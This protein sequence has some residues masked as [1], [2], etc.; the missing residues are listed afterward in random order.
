MATSKKFKLCNSSKAADYYCVK[1]YQPTDDSATKLIEICKRQKQLDL[2]WKVWQERYLQ[3]LREKL[4]LEHKQ[5]RFE[6][7]I[8]PKEGSIV[9]V[10]NKSVTRSNWKL[11]KI[12][13]L[14]PSNDIEVRVVEILRLGQS[15][16]PLAIN[17][18]YE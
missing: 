3:N 1:D 14:I 4:P 17:Y 9:I 5:A 6:N 15:T 18:Y 16:I 11:G 13:C 7:L 10:K 8:E 12:L 2:F